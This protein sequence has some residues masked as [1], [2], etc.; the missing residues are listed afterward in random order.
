METLHP[1]RTHKVSDG[2]L[3][4][5]TKAGDRQAFEEL[6]ARYEQRVLAVAQRIVSNREDAEDV[7]Q[8]SFYK[9]FLHLG[10]FR[11]KSLF[12]TWITRIAM[13]EAFMLLRRRTRTPEASQDGPDDGAEELAATF[14]DQSPNPEQSCW[15]QERV[16]CLNK[17]IHRLSPKLRKAIVLFDIE[18]HSI[19]DTA[20]ILGM[21]ISAVKSRLNHG[22]EKLRG[23]MNLELLQGS[24]RA[25]LGRHV[26][27]RPCQ[28]ECFPGPASGG[29]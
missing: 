14:V 27:V 13:N 4:D 20:R 3:V 6:I 11:G 10:G 22:R 1:A 16:E 28:V 12:S 25:H 17:A 26:D 18:E 8:E 2:E 24:Q 21:S 15:Q 19:N 23:G 29:N 5:A 9:A 7:V